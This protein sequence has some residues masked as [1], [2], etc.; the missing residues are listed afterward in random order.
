MH[1]Q[2]F[3]RSEQHGP[4]ALIAGGIAVYD[5]DDERIGTVERAYQGNTSAT[6]ADRGQAPATAG[7]RPDGETRSST[8]SPRSPRRTIP[9]PRRSVGGSCGAGSSRSTP[10]ATI[11]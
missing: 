9:R 4:L 11:A 1:E 3:A 2:P 10:C 8:P 5:R 7:R 6:A